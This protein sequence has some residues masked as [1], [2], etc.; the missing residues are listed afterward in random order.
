MKALYAALI[1]PLLC[2]GSPAKAELFPCTGAQREVYKAVCADAELVRLDKA[3]DASL[4]KL[5]KA[6]DPLTAMLLRRDQRWFKDIVGAQGIEAFDDT[7]TTERKH[8]FDA[9]QG[10]L[11]RLGRLRVGAAPTSL[12]GEW[13]NVHGLVQITK[14]RG[15]ALRVRIVS[16]V[17]YAEDE[18]GHVCGLTAIVK[19]E[20]GWYE[21]EPSTS[22]SGLAEDDDDD[23]DVTAEAE[24]KDGDAEDNSPRLRLRL[25]GNTLRVVMEVNDEDGFCNGPSSLTGSYFAGIRGASTANAKPEEVAARTVSPSFRCDTARRSDAE[26]ICADPDLAEHDVELARTYK[27]ALEELK[28]ETA[29]HLSADQRAWVLSNADAFDAYFLPAW[30]KRASYVHHTDDARG[31]LETRQNERIAM[32]ENLDQ[33]REGLV[34]RWVAHNAMLTVAPAEGKSD[35]TLHA[36]GGIWRTGD[37][38]SHCEFEADGTLAGGTFKTGVA[39]PKLAL[40]GATL[41]L[42]A[43]DPTAEGDGASRGPPSYCTRMNSAK[44]R[45]FPVKDDAEIGTLYNRVR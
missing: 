14:G 20:E 4:Q 40:D 32:L 16:Q 23:D 33:D 12:V 13:G 1:V 37:T 44:A 27:E 28:P 45:L 41:T 6:A 11:A 19:P 7:N 9:L 42:D 3:V 17:T 30:D 25:Q 35:G 5:L 31:E 34:G 8:V 10:R 24:D 22:K 21:G 15:D 29:G 38:K 2:A 36:S 43:D 39:F 26:E 18:K